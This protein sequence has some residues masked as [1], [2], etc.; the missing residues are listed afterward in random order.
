MGGNEIVFTS[1]AILRCIRWSVVS[2]FNDFWC[3]HRCWFTR[4]CAHGVV[5]EGLVLEADLL[6]AV[7][8][9]RVVTVGGDGLFSLLVSLYSSRKTSLS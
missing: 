5:L 2:W 8:L 4:T 3:A 6:M 9:S 7:L 1:F